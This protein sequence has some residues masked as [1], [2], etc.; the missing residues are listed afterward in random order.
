VV[1]KG[2]ASPTKQAVNANLQESNP[3]PALLLLNRKNAKPDK[4]ALW[5][6]QKKVH[7]KN[8]AIQTQDVKNALVIGTE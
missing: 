1:L 7:V 6:S 2:I 8:L 4:E 3:A 5:T